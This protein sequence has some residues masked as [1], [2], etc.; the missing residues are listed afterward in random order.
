MSN[1]I[2]KSCSLTQITIAESSRPCVMVIILSG[3]S[4]PTTL[5]TATL[6]LLDGL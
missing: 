3:G 6:I 1:K 2:E 4:I 5:I